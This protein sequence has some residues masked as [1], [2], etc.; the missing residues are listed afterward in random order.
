MVDAYS[1]ENAF[2]EKCR[3]IVRYI[4]EAGKP[5]AHGVLLKKSHESAEMLKQIIDTLTENG[6]ITVS[7]VGEGAKTAKVY[8]M[9]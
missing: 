5:I 4:G 6:T 2:D 1:F 8:A 7:F 9:A 3:K